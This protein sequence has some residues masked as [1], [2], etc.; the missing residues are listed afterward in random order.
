M[1]VHF[2]KVLAHGHQP[3]AGFRALGILQCV[4]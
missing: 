3:R 1:P 2:P 4:A